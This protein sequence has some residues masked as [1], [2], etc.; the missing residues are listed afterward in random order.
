MSRVQIASGPD[1]EYSGPN[2]YTA[3]GIDEENQVHYGNSDWITI[4]TARGNFTGNED[5]FNTVVDKAPLTKPF[6]YS[7]AAQYTEFGSFNGGSGAQRVA[8]GIKDVERTA[9]YNHVTMSGNLQHAKVYQ[10][11]KTN[12]FS[13]EFRVFEN[14]SFISVAPFMYFLAATYPVMD[15]NTK[16]AILDRIRSQATNTG[17]LGYVENIVA[18]TFGNL[19]QIF[20]SAVKSLTSEDEYL[21]NSQ[22]DMMNAESISDYF[23]AMNGFDKTFNVEIGNLVKLKNMVLNNFNVTFSRERRWFRNDPKEN[24]PQKPPITLPVYIDY[25]INL[26]P[27]I[28]PTREDVIDWFNSDSMAYC[29]IMSCDKTK[30][31]TIPEPKPNNQKLDEQRMYVQE[32]KTSEKEKAKPKSPTRV[33]VQYTINDYGDTNTD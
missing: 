7:A 4:K 17:V 5:W 19:A 6:S 24:E 13:F 11:S 12:D 31:A 10:G 21:A 16:E 28:E 20:R 29:S 30:V 25:S 3:H 18:G 1:Y 8:A 27:I 2:Y 32:V 9:V 22:V 26:S 33:D 14:G 23:A 15:K